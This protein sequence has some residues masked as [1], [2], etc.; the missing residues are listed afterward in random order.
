MCKDASKLEGISLSR[1][2]IIDDSPA[3]LAS[4]PE[5]TIKVS[6]WEGDLEDNELICIIPLLKKVY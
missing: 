4:H 6:K 5:N 1:A 2:I 3:V